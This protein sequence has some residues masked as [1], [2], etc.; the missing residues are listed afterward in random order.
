MLIQQISFALAFYEDIVQF[1]HKDY[2]QQ[3]I[4]CFQDVFRVTISCLPNVFQDVFKTLGK[5]EIL[6]T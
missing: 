3:T 5:Q 2:S 1:S 6:L 4:V